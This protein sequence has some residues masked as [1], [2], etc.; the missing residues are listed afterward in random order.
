MKLVYSYLHPDYILHHLSRLQGD[1]QALSRLLGIGL[2]HCYRRLKQFGIEI[3]EE[4]QR[5]R[6]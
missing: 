2:Q 4:R 3:K 5:R 1:M 6:E